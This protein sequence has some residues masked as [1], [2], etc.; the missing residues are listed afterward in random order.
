MNRQQVYSIQARSEE[1]F[2][3]FWSAK[4][5]PRIEMR[6]LLYNFAAADLFHQQL[7]LLV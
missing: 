5:V 7:L 3:Y 2:S 1:K 4:A 6:N